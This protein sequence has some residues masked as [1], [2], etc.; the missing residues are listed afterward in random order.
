MIC[1]LLLIE[2]LRQLLL[3][4]EDFEEKPDDHPKGEGEVPENTD[5]V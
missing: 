1:S 5:T 4:L 2:S 3:S